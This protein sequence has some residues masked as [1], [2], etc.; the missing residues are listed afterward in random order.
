MAGISRHTS[1]L[2]QFLLSQEDGEFTFDGSD[3]QLYKR[4]VR[5]VRGLRSPSDAQAAIGQLT[6]L[7][8]AMLSQNTRSERRG[9][10]VLRLT[11]AGIAHFRR[12]TRIRLRTSEQATGLKA[13]G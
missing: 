1:A 9:R 7:R 5:A 2:A 11:P 8:L 12:T 3:T 10:R 6:F 4:L 13:A